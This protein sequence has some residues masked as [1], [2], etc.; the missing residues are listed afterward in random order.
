MLGGS[1]GRKAEE[2]RIIFSSSFIHVLFTLF[3]SQIARIGAISSINLCFD[4][5]DE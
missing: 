2:D 4:K 3:L 1:G 5:L